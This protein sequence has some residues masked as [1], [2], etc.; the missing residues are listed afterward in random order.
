MKKIKLCTMLFLTAF[1]AFA[2]NSIKENNTFSLP[3][4]IETMKIASGGILLVGTSEG[5]TAIEAHSN[6][7]AYQYNTLGKIKPEEMTMMDNY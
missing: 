1:T 5:L 7:V 4:T 2:Q 3:G 6:N